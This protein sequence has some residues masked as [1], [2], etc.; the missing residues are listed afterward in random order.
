MSTDLIR[1]VRET[2]LN[3]QNAEYI[4]QLYEAFKLDPNSVPEQWRHYFYGFEHAQLEGGAASQPPQAGAN[5]ATSETQVH[6]VAEKL[7]LAYRQL[8]HLCARTDPL[9]VDYPEKPS[10]LDPAYYGLDDAALET[11]VD[12][13]CLDPSKPLPLRD[14]VQALEQ[15][16]CGSL[17]TEYL[18][19][20]DAEERRWLE[21]RLESTRG[22]WQGQLDPETRRGILGDLTAAEGLEQYLHR[23][24]I[25]Q[26]RFSLEGGDSLIPLLDEVVQGGGELGIQNIVIGMAH[27]GRLNVLVNLMGKSPQELFDE[28][29]GS[30]QDESGGGSGDVKYHQGFYSSIRSRGGPVHVSLAFN[31]SHLEIVCPVVE[32]GVRARQDRIGDEGVDH[33][34]PVLIH[35]DAA[36]IGQGVTTETLNLSETEGYRTGGSLHIVINNQIGFTT[37][38]PIEARST[39][40]CTEVAKMV[41]APIFHVNGDDPDAVVFVTRLALEYRKAFNNDVVIDLVCYR[42]QGHNEADEPMMTQPEMYQVIRQ[43]ETTRAIYARRLKR[44]KVIQPGVAEQLV[45]EYRR[46]L[47]QGKVTVME[48]LEGS[49][50]GYV[51]NDWH[52]FIDANPRAKYDTAVN[53]AELKRLGKRTTS[54]PDGFVLHSRVAKVLEARRKMIQGE[55]RLDWGMAE[56]LAFASLLEEGV[57]IRMSGQDVRRGT[58]SHR[59]AVLHDQETA[60][61]YIPL[62]QVNTEVRFDIINSMLSELAV[63][64]FEYG[65]ATS[66]PNTLVIWEAQFGDF[67]N[68]AQPVIDQFISSGFVKWG[69]FCQLTLFLPHGFEGQGPEHSSA[70]L[71]RYLQLCAELNM[72]VWYPSTPAQLFHLL[73]DQHI[74]DFRRPLVVMT[75]KSLLRN[76]DSTSSLED[77]STGKLELVIDEVDELR[78]E[79]VRRVVACSGKIYFDLLKQRRESRMLDVAILRIE[80]LYPFPR[81]TLNRILQQYPNAREL[82]WCQ[83]EPR[84]QGAWYQIQH[85]LRVAKLVTMSLGYSGR[86][87]SASPAAGNPREH[88]QQHKYL[89]ERALDLEPVDDPGERLEDTDIH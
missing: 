70:R 47:D 54:V 24:Y 37:S 86:P 66:S 39:L 35:G 71:E 89:V 34:L 68:C 6:R 79:S 56:N 10:E 23:K 53:A 7:I 17:A 38:L 43:L 62:K 20:T 21:H 76:P 67:G 13:V 19:I 48:F 2:G 63:L 22:D 41:Q 82:V 44:Q 87:P 31:P 75:P 12:H 74:R 18:H 77:L 49:R 59:H 14:I 1:S 42:R 16:Y 11:E 55:Q 83:E 50:R 61:R 45:D 15:V 65:Y 36:F 29:E 5:Q 8:G 26:K 88:L 33:V 85:H 57:A 84:N 60:E 52:R 78:S 28:F 3:V 30:Y 9:A 40:Y 25:G 46:T 32:G 4:D 81:R 80:Q 58:F 64:G 69:R 73:R 51:T 72:R 27:R